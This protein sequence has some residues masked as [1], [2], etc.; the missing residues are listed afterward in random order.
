MRFEG[1]FRLVATACLCALAPA[2]AQPAG[3]S[4]G[5]PVYGSCVTDFSCPFGEECEG[6]GCA[7]IPAS[8][9]PHIQTASA[10]SRAAIDDGEQAWRAAHCDLNISRLNPDVMRAQNPNVKLF[11]YGIARYH[12]FDG[13]NNAATDWAIAHGYDPEDFYLHYKED[14]FVPIWSG[15]QLVPGFPLGVVPGWNPA[16]G[17]NPASATERW[18]SR[19]VGNNTG[20]PWYLGNVAH[21]GYRAFLVEYATSLLEGTWFSTTPFASGPVDGIM[22][23]VSLYYPQFLEGQIEKTTE[24]Y[25]VPITDDH[26]YAIAVETVYPFLA[27]EMNRVFGTAK[28]IMPNFGHVLFLNHP[29]R[30]ATNVRASTPWILGE[31]WVTF[32]GTWF[33]TSGATR[34]ITYDKDYNNAVAN[35]IVQTRARSRRVIGARD[36]SNGT[37]GTDQGKIFT[38][39]LYYLVH[40]LHTYYNYAT[41]SH[42]QLPGHIS[43][44][45]WNPAVTYDVGQPDVVPAGTVDFAGNAN[46][47]EHYLFATGADPHDNA[48]TYRVFARNFTN[49][50]VLVKML[51]EGSVTDERSITVHTLDGTYAPLLA[52]GNIGAAV[53]EAAIRNNE[54][55]ILIRLDQTGIRRD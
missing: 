41:A 42:S 1:L 53:T 16:G 38:L 23:D 11:E 2:C 29:N 47:K 50:L 39:G 27:Q 4:V 21:P 49:A 52:D 43:T 3:P 40:N 25:G 51:P 54:A 10:L 14:V 46:T 48:L 37:A 7:P 8:I 31:V 44:W 35:I 18:Q 33:P 26:P 34:C 19:V 17:G 45:S 13:L 15:V 12:T 36:L 55:L 22:F 32:T 24:Y 20:E 5:G 9:Y 28:D 30:S 6:S